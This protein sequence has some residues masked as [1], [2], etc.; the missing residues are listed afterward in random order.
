MKGFSGSSLSI[1]IM[2]TTI[3]YIS[4]NLITSNITVKIVFDLSRKKG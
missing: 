2:E 1:K 4:K 3:L